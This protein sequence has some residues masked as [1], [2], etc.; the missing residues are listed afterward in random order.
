MEVL[1]RPILNSQLDIV[2]EANLQAAGKVLVSATVDISTRRKK[3][4]WDCPRGLCP[5]KPNP[6]H[7][8]HFFSNHFIDPSL[9]EMGRHFRKH[10]G[11]KSRKLFNTMDEETLLAVDTERSGVTFLK[12]L[13]QHGQAGLRS[14]CMIWYWAT[15]VVL[16]YTLKFLVDRTPR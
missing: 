6:A 16:W 12:W 2:G 9:N 1:G 13:I 4:L 15:A 11:L 7:N 8:T 5:T 14:F 10:S 3:L